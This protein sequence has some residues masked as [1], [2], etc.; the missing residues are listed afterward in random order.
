MQ[1]I[2][3]SRLHSEYGITARLFTLRFIVIPSETENT[4]RFYNIIPTALVM[5]HILLDG[6]LKTHL[7]KRW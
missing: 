7:S 2:V 1:A 4:F 6:R 5:Q 3:Y